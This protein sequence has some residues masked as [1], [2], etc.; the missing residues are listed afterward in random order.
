[1]HVQNGE[2]GKKVTYCHSLQHLYTIAIDKYGPSVM[3]DRLTS[4]LVPWHNTYMGEN[5]HFSHYARKSLK[6]TSNKTKANAQS[7]LATGATSE[8]KIVSHT[9]STIP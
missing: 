5:Y 3:R 9:V 4:T 8:C 1:M 6:K 2:T 7:L